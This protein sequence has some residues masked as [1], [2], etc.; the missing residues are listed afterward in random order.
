M[1]Q[2]WALPPRIKILEALGAIADDRIK[3]SDN[4]AAV[5]GSAGDRR[6]KVDWDG[7]MKIACDDSGSVHKG[8]LGYPALALLMVKGVLP[9]DRK[10]S[11][12]LKGIRWRELNEKYKA[13]W[14]T[15]F[16]VG[17]I[18]NRKGVPDS[19]INTYCDAVLAKLRKLKLERLE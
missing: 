6:Y 15:E 13:Y 11:E 1:A 18:L 3:A 8:Y 17:K 7:G 12:G 4:S 5:V 19:E 10:M 16:V 14:K 9:V 2:L